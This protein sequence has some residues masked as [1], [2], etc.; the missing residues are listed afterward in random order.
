MIYNIRTYTNIFAT[1][2]CYIKKSQYKWSPG[3][4]SAS[5]KQAAALCWQ[6]LPLDCLATRPARQAH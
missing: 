6:N 1:Y 5:A 4:P 3:W 2:I